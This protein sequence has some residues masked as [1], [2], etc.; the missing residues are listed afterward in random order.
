MEN[1][2]ARNRSYCSRFWPDGR[3]FL[4]AYNDLGVGGFRTNFFRAAVSV[5]LGTF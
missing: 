2:T 3:K 4:P 1:S 5:S